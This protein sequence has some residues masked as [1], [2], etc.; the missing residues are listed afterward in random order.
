MAAFV[1]AYHMRSLRSQGQISTVHHG[2]TLTT[3]T[4]ALIQT[5][6]HQCY[7]ILC[8]PG[9]SR[10]TGQLFHVYPHEEGRPAKGQLGAA[11]R[12]P[13]AECKTVIQQ[14]SQFAMPLFCCPRSCSHA[15]DIWIGFSNLELMEISEL[16]AKHGI[17]NISLPEHKVRSSSN[18]CG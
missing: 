2:M 13:M 5:Y 8:C 3:Y 9:P 15:H 12:R 16:M 17:V 1:R 4:C 18:I 7:H 11:I 10:S 6:Q 14:I